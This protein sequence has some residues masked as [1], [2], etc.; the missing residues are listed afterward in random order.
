[1][2]LFLGKGFVDDALRGRVDPGIG[3]GVEPAPEL[4]VEIIEIAEYAA[5]EEV[6]A[7]IP[8]RALHLALGLRP[9][10][11]AGLGLEAVVA[12]QIKQASVVDNEAVGILADDGGLHAVVENLMRHPADRFQGDNV[13][14]QHG[15]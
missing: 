6:F 14:A 10:G 3:D 11:P 2:R 4:N 13:T 15:L 8:E 12:G 5:E 1:M 9:I 7:D